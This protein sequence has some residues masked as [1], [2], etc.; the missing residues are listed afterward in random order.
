M[1]YDGRFLCVLMCS[2]LTFDA[3][4]FRYLWYRDR[5]LLQITIVAKCSEILI[6]RN[7]ENSCF[8]TPGLQFKLK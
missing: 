2:S 1:N 6:G 5:I 8:Q 7:L 3:S 4:Y